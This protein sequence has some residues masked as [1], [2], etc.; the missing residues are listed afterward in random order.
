MMTT[1]HYP[2]KCNNLQ[3][4]NNDAIMSETGVS[5]AASRPLAIM[6][7]SRLQLTNPPKI[8]ARGCDCQPGSKPVRGW[9]GMKGP[10]N[11]GKTLMDMVS[12]G[13][14]IGYANDNHDN[15]NNTYPDV[16]DELYL[17]SK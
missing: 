7:A 6:T 5:S 1:T 3:L 9:A 15:M 10:G 12:P 13:A 14:N 17:G 2:W 16:Q 8:T 11:Y 4:T